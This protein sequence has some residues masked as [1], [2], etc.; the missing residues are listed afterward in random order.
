M[1]II[2]AQYIE[3][4]LLYVLSVLLVTEVMVEI[5]A[6]VFKSIFPILGRKKETF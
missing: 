1:N 5:C 3:D 2:I 4:V 6:E